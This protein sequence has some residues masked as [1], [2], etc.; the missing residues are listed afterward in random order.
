M[1]TFIIISGNFTG[2]SFFSNLASGFLQ[3]N[4]QSGVIS[5][6]TGFLIVV[7]IVLGVWSLFSWYA[8]QP[9]EYPFEPH[10][11]E[12]HEIL[13][14]A[15]AAVHDELELIEGIGPKIASVFH[16][17]GITTFRQLAETEVMH[18]EQILKEAGIRLGD[19]TTWPEQAKLAALGD[20]HG[21]KDLQS[22]LKG[23]RRIE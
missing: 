20:W 1:S 4:S 8:K 17:A 13:E 3:P 19:P 10:S 9:L 5:D 12:V 21:L 16:E 22:T 6:F 2:T 15:S 18:L 11:L 7:A 23:G 14:E